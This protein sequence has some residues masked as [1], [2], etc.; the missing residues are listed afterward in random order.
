MYL[1]FDIGGTKMRVARSK[2]GTVFDRYTILPTPADFKVGM[3]KFEEIGLD[4]LEGK[5]VQ[6]IAGGIAGPVLKNKSGLGDARNLPGWARQPFVKSLKKIFGAKVPVHIEND[7]A[8]VG[9]GEAHFGAGRGAGILVYITIS[10]GVGG[11]RIVHGGI[12]ANRYG[13]EPGHQII[14]FDTAKNSCSHCGE[15]GHLEGYVSGTALERKYGKHASEITDMKV[16]KEAGRVL[17]I[18]LANTILH[19]SPDRVV[20][21]GSMMKVPGIPLDAVRASLKEHLTIFDDLPEIK[22]ATLGDLGGL[23]G[24]LVLIRQGKKVSKVGASR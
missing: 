18:G 12:D 11:V 19:W 22:K 9:L 1:V 16:W 10:T 6:G 23:Y 2:D 8:V 3:Q 14:D 17:G 7:T 15:S 24:G 20:L 13:F 21:G 4:L 5:K